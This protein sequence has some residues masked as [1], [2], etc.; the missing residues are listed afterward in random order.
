MR[1][2]H[3]WQTD[4]FNWGPQSGSCLTPLGAITFWADILTTASFARHWFS[5]TSIRSGRVGRSNECRF[6]SMK[7][8]ALF[9]PGVFD[10][11]ASLAIFLAV[12]E[13]LKKNWAIG[14]AANLGIVHF[15]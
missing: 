10:M 4:W 12:I 3:C 8:D 9:G 5:A 15:R 11:K 2:Q 13:E 1:W 6:G 7:M 14:A